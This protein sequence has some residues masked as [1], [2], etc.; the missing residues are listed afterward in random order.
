MKANEELTLQEIELLCQAYIDCHLTRL[1]EKELELVLL[2]SDLTSPVIAEVRSL[3]GLTTLMSMAHTDAIDTK[4][5]K[6]R[7]FR[8][9]GIAASVAIIA[10]CAVSFMISRFAAGPVGDVYACV[11]GKVLTGNEAQSVVNDT[12]EETMNMFRSIIEETE[13]EQS[14]S[15]QYMNSLID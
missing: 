15:E 6:P 9:A 10:M 4:R 1:Q 8:Y 5:V 13:D 11:D 14:L 7:V 12:E 2:C 3:M